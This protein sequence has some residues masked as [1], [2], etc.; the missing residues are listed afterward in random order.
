MLNTLK[1]LLSIALFIPLT[2]LGAPA[3]VRVDVLPGNP[4]IVFKWNKDRCFDENIPDSA[5]RAFRVNSE[6]VQLYATHFKNVP[7]VGSTLDD[8]KPA[9]HTQFAATFDAKPENYDA[10]IWL[11]SF[12]STGMGKD[13]YS[14]GSSDYHGKW[15]GKCTLKKS[16]N[17]DCWMSAI[18][19]ARST[20]GGQTFSTASPPKHIVANSPEK[21]SSHQRGSAG[22]LTTSNIVKVDQHFYSLFYASAFKN[23]T[24]GNCLARTD[25]LADPRSWHA[26]DGDNFD[27]PLYNASGSAH[28]GRTCT[29]LANLPYK[30]RSLLWHAPSHGYVATF[31]K[32]M[33]IKDPSPR[34]DVTFGFAWS[35][36]LKVW[37][38][39]VAIT[40]LKGASN[41][42]TPQ[43]AGAYPSII[44][45]QSSDINFGTV[46]D[47]AYLYY[48]KFNLQANCRLTLDRDLVR[49]PI[50]VRLISSR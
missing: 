36:D 6:Q 4:E 10:R 34:T 41:C 24:G 29:P 45:S 8:V 48:T 5:A 18:V 27:Q 43:V 21:Y 47:H 28:G 2:A 7:F 49:I 33:R 22:F 50:R 3:P 31:E 39:P 19:L 12:Y 40:T 17:H 15:F 44:D 14:L 11:Q 46:D 23:Q 30:I 42:S 16:S 26:W 1:A 32:T 37:S 25:N 20:D 38:D 13:V 35:R 9:C